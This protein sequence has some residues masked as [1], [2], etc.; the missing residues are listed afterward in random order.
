MAEEQN[1]QNGHANIGAGDAPRDH[2]QRK[3]I[4]PP[5]IQNNNFEI[6]SGLISMIQGNKFHGLPMEDPLDHLDE[7]DRLCNLTKINGVS[8][9]GFKLRLFPFSLGDKAHIWE[10]NLPHDSITTWDDCKK[11]FLSK[12]FS[13]A[14]TARLKNEISGFSQKTSESFCEAWERFKGYTNQCPH[15]G[16]TKASLLSTLYRGVL[17][18]IRMLLDTASNGNFQNKDVEEGWELVENLAQS[19]GNYNEDCD[20]T[21]RG[22]ADSDDKH[23]KEI[24]ALNDKLDRILLS[25][26]KHVHFLVDDEHTNVANPQDQVYPPQQQQGQNK[27]FVPYN[28]GFVPKQQF[29]GN[30]QQPPPPGFAPQQNQGPAAPDAEMKQMVQQLLQGQASSSMEMA[31]KLSELHH[32]LDCS[33]N[34]LNAKVEAL[35]TKVR[36]LEG[37]LASTSA[38]NVTGLPGKSIQNP[39][40]Y[41]TAHAITICQDRE[42][43]TRPDP[44]FITEDSDVQEGEASTQ[45]EV[46][47]VEFNHSAG[48]R[49][50]TQSIS[51]EKAAIIEK[52]VKRFKPTPLPSRALPW[53]FRKAWM[54]RYKSIAAKQLDEIEAVMP[55][56]EVLNLIPDPHKDVRNLILERIKMYHDSDDESDAT[57]S[58]AADKRI[59]Q[60]KL[61]DPGSFTLPCSIGEF[62]F[63]DCLCDLGASVSL[64]P[65]SMARRLEFIQYKPCDL[66]LILADRSSRK[67]F[68]MLK[69]L[70]VMIN[71]VEVPTDFVV[72]DME[73]EHKDPLILGRPFLA[74]AGAVID[75]REGKISLNLGKHIKLQFGINKTPQGS[76]EDGRTSGNDRAISGEGY[77]TKRVKELRKKSNKQNETI[78]KLAH[79]NEELRSKLNQ[80]QKEAQ[81]KGGINTIPR[82]E[83]TSR[84]SQD[85][86]YPPEEKEAYFEERGIEYSAANLSREDA[87]Y[88][89]EATKSSRESFKF[90]EDCGISWSFSS[91]QRIQRRDK[92]T[93]RDP[94]LTPMSS[95][96][97]TKR[98]GISSLPLD[99]HATPPSLD[100]TSITRPCF[101]LHNQINSTP[102][103]L[104]QRSLFLLLLDLDAITIPTPIKLDPIPLIHHN[105]QTH[106]HQSQA[107]DRFSLAS[108]PPS[109]ATTRSLLAISFKIV[110]H[111][112]TLDFVI[113]QHQQRHST[114][115]HHR[116]LISRVQPSL[117]NTTVSSLPRAQVHSTAPLL[118]FKATLL[119][120]YTPPLHL[121]ITR[122]LES[123]PQLVSNPLVTRPRLLH[124]FIALTAISQH[125]R[126][127]VVT[128]S[129]CFSTPLHRFIMSNYSGEFSMDPDYNVDEAESWSARPREQHVYQSFRDEL[130]R[131][132]ARH[133]QRRAEI[134]R[135]KRAMSSRYE[136]IDEDIETEYEPE[137]WRRETK[138]LN[139]P[140]EVTVEEYIRFFEMNDFWGTRYPCYETLAQLGLLEDVQHL[141]E[142]CHLETPMSYPYPAY[143]E[144]TIEF[145]S[146]LQVEMYE[147]L[148]DFE[149]DAMGLGF[150]TFLVNEQRYQL[151]IKKLEELFG[152]PSGKGT[153]P[154]FDREELKD[155]WAT[156]GNNL[157]LNSARD[158][159]PDEGKNVLRG[160]LNNAPP[161]MPLLMHLC[162]YRKWAL[163]NGKKKVRGALWVGGVVT[164]ILE[165]CGVPLKEPGLAPRM[166]DLDHL[167]RCEFLEFDMAGDFHRYRFEHSSIRIANILLPCIDATRILEGRNIDF[168]PALE[169]LYFEGSPPTEEFSHTEGATTE[170]VDEMDDIDEAE[171]DTSMYHFSEHIPPTR[172]SK[173]L[174]EAHRNN[175]KLQKW[176]KKQDKLLAKCLR[177]IKFLKDKLS[178][179]SSTTAIPQGH[180]PQDMPSR[181]YDAPEP[182]RRR[183]EPRDRS[184]RLLQSRSLRDRGAGRSRRREVEFPQSGAGR[185]RADEV[186]YPPAG[187]DTEQ[188]GD[189]ELL[190]SYLEE[191]DLIT[192]NHSTKRS[193][194]S[195]KIPR[196]HSTPRSSI[197]HHHFTSPLD[198]FTPPGSR[199]SSDTTRSPHSTPRSSA[200]TFTARPLLDL[201]T[202]PRGR[203]PPSHRSTAYSMTSFRAFFIPHSTRHS[204]TRKKRRLQLF[205]RPLT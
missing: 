192:T 146:T 42:L 61:E 97:E 43:P 149:L 13:N 204:S 83:F 174:S 81:P 89:D 111:H 40:K 138:L 2:R 46:S 15:H 129:R 5:A 58:R 159:P 131:S 176:C 24:K 199:V 96:Q 178:C 51:E 202:L 180:L 106:P 69:D 164:P 127:C 145:L 200:F 52:M 71:G 4:A 171:F 183:P 135:G 68:G 48:S 14:R 10:K 125:T 109:R 47:V 19:D 95:M 31:K 1:Q 84:W 29:Q 86:D 72:L 113:P 35:N 137:S 7:F 66:T 155:L 64:M 196:D 9:D 16:F 76:T 22:T 142:K 74:S 195:F 118:P 165:A 25:Q 128:R 70:P 162:G 60:E 132:T 189:L 18:R 87:E 151:S 63:S 104:N 85:T 172:E 73:V 21:I 136:L 166:M 38:P 186:E 75:V 26:H 45:V 119:R 133:N 184:G 65:L 56:M 17:P 143:K 193:S 82:K 78:E 30:Y 191:A 107:H 168:K 194:R 62:A 141:F 108:S 179:S 3:G 77:E 90:T 102:S 190:T 158:S 94:P 88:D 182:S 156:I 114:P 55:L 110:S 37:Q 115:Y 170:D 32:K 50:L 39:K 154:R 6:K 123:P 130:E 105:Q 80:M 161:V 20:R 49:H 173:S 54:E 99:H 181:R 23:R 153:K 126:P 53:T 8:E 205:T 91:E 34:D 121:I 139:K 198:L 185:H 144:E 93:T 163:T 148:T 122:S 187:A 197:G 147:A 44:D 79:T 11:A 152:F 103:F 134:A 57:P 12:F 160:D 117:D 177:A 100:I 28:Q 92:K 188:G 169:D 67:P 36:Y 201:I 175:S 41:A 124:S 167:R 120:H 33:Y 157:P 98:H 59:V 112:Q 116:S 140:D 101:L 203:V 27:P 150:L